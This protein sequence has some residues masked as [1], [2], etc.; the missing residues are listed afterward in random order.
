MNEP[1]KC[2]AYY[3]EVFSIRL[4]KN[5]IIQSKLFKTIVEA[6]IFVQSIQY[7][8]NELRITLNGLV[9]DE[10]NYDIVVI[11]KFVEQLRGLEL[12]FTNKEYYI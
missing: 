2:F 4:D 11:G 6:K 12:V 10:E 7:L 5:Y 3:V 9:G 8:D 1:K